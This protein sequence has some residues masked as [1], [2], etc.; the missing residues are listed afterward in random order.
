[1][2]GAAPRMHQL[3]DNLLT[4]SRFSKGAQEIKPTDMNECVSR[5]LSDLDVRI[6]TK[7]ASINVGKLPTIQADRFQLEQLFLNLLS[8]A[9]KFSEEGKPPV[10]AIEE[11]EASRLPAAV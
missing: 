5:I 8:N 3:I 2:S 1:M 4:Y 10:I 11:V 6:A 9:L 7:G